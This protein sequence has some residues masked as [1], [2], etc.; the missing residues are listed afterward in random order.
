MPQGCKK[1]RVRGQMGS[2]KLLD[3]AEQYK[4]EPWGLN[5]SWINPLNICYEGLCGYIDNIFNKHLNT[6]FLSILIVLCGVCIRHYCVLYIYLFIFMLKTIFK[7]WVFFVFFVLVLLSKSCFMICRWLLKC[8]TC[9]EMI[10]YYKSSM[11]YMDK[12]VC[13]VYIIFIINI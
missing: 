2:T 11:K 4:A 1:S 5:A 12:I 8:K 9:K 7:R 10:M 13:T 3:K 6:F